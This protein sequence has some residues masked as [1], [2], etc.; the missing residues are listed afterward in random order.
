MIHLNEFIL[1]LLNDSA[2]VAH[3]AQKDPLAGATT[4]ALD[5]T[6]ND[7]LIGVSD[8]WV[9]RSIIHGMVQSGA[10]RVAGTDV[11][12]PRHIHER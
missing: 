7:R 10:L 5:L 3:E 6:G 1:S 11:T 4:G 12:I 2:A 8:S 9:Y